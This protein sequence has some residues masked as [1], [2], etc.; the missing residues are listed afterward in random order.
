[1][2]I[3]L[4]KN[5]FSRNKEKSTKKI[6]EEYSTYLTPWYFK[7]SI[8]KLGENLFWKEIETLNGEKLALTSLNT[9]N[10]CIGILDMY[11]YIKPLDKGKFLIWKRGCRK[12]E[13]YNISDL[14]PIEPTKTK[15]TELK[16]AYKFNA[17]PIDT[18]E[19]NFDLYQTEIEFDFP[20]S[21]SEIDEIIQVNDLDGMYK[22]YDESMMNTAIVVLKPKSNKVEIYPQDW[23]NR[24]KDIDFG[25]QWIT[26]ADRIGGTEKIKIQGIR[27]GSYELDNTYRQI[28]K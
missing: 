25:Y 22:D 5:I 16:K 14:K 3:N 27:L 23:F 4:F 1:M 20:N 26:R 9:K 7:G 28:V 10:D 18:I 12:I 13:L 2:I 17:E 6:L 19:Y 21:F 8:P 24:A 11:C 15:W